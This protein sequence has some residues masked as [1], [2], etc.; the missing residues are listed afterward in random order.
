MHGTK[1]WGI[2][3][4]VC[5]D[6]SK[7]MGYLIQLPKILGGYVIKRIHHVNSLGLNGSKI[8]AIYLVELQ[9]IY[10]IF[11]RPPEKDKNL[12]TKLFC[13]CVLVIS[14]IK[15]Y[16]IQLPNIGGYVIKRS[17]HVSSLGLNRSKDLCNLFS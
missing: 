13:K 6:D 15:K 8:H 17:H 14:E 5:S 1:A 12:W 10:E 16:L 4:Q 7:L 2:N 3:L 11:G 9:N